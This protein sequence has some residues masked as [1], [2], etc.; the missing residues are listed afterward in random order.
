MDARPLTCAAGGA[1]RP[2]RCPRPLPHG[3]G[4]AARRGGGRRGHRR[5]ATGGGTRAPSHSASRRAG[6]PPVAHDGTARR[7][8][9]PQDP[10]AQ[11]AR[12]SGKTKDH[13][14][15]NVLLVNAPLTILLLRATDGGRAHAKRIA[16]ATPSPFPAGSRLLQDVG[17]LAFM[18]SQV[19][20]RM[21]T[22]QPHGQELT[23]EQHVANQV[24]HY[25]RLRIEPVNRSG[26]RCR[27]VTDRIRLWKPASVLSSWPSAVSA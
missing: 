12:E 8:V 5:H 26:K 2:R 1:A 22:K 24:L 11:T 13:T 23:R 10:A 18:L 7:I 6:V 27:V 4:A 16:A 17:C 25:R 3:L 19:A 15:N 20:I 21:P 9:R 14:G